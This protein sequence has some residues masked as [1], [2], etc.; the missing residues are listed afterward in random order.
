LHQN[1]VTPDQEIRILRYV[2]E[3]LLSVEADDDASF[4]IDKYCLLRDATLMLM[5]FEIAPRPM[6]IY[7]SER[8]HLVGQE[9]YFSMRFIRNKNR[10]YGEVFTTQRAIS[11]RLGLAMR[12][13]ERLSQ[14]LFGHLGDSK[15][16]CFL[17]A[18]GKRM[19][20]KAISVAVSKALRLIF[21]SDS[22]DVAG[23]TTV[24]R[25]HLG[26]SLADQGA[27]P[28][29]IADRLGHSTEA[30]AR[31]YIAATPNIAKIKTR[32]LGNNETY[33]YLIA[34]LMTGSI[35]R[36]EEVE[37]AAAMVRGTVG[38]QYI[39]GIGMCDVKGHCHSNPVLAC[40]TCRKFH[41]FVD[42][43]HDRVIE[44]LQAHVITFLEGAADIQ[45]SRPITQLELAI[46]SARAISE[47]CKRYGL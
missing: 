3:Q 13:L 43:P 9:G 44:A 46:E 36:R 16:P 27:P 19:P 4:N 25:H 11:V 22:L 8:N 45:H 42:G 18:D 33:K 6:Q 34:A 30:A 35:M 15:A 14:L 21:N 31:A 37:D 20:S 24:F 7:M 28:A 5:A 17:D 47:E 23:A 29:V 40:Y 32:A 1:Y 38:V 12:R 41:P 26:Q 10:H 2:D 39:E